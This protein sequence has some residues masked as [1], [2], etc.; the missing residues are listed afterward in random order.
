MK[1]IC[2]KPSNGNIIRKVRPRDPSA[3]YTGADSTVE[4]AREKAYASPSSSTHPDRFTD[5][6]VT[7]PKDDI[8]S[9]K[10]SATTL[11]QAIESNIQT[12][13]FQKQERM[14]C[15][16]SIKSQRTSS[17]NEIES[18]G[19]RHEQ[20]RVKLLEDLELKQRNERESMTKKIGDLEKQKHKEE[21]QLQEIQDRIEKDI[22][23]KAR[24]EGVLSYNY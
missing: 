17:L 21:K 10:S 1:L 19:R 22:E 18:L 3:I 23:G 13:E 4:I 20:Q 8:T 12:C 6:A 14:M 5:Q 11:L 9:F 15:L 7:D 16:Q 24:L 2:L